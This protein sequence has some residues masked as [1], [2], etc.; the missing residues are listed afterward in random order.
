ML[1][2]PPGAQPTQFADGSRPLAKWWGAPS[3]L[4]TK[5]GKLSRSQEEEFESFLFFWI[6]EDRR[7]GNV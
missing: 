6:F 4:G 5:G 1:D 2:Y 7:I 3:V